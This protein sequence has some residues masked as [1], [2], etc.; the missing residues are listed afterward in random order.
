M[1]KLF[2]FL[3]FSIFFLQNSEAQQLPCIPIPGGIPAG[4]EAPGCMLCSPVYQGSTAGY[5]ASAPGSSGFPCGTVENNSFIS[6][7]VDHTGYLAA[8]VLSANCQNGQGIQIMLYDQ[9]F[10]PVSNCFSSGGTNLPGNVQA[11][12]L[13]PGEVYWLMIDGFAGDICDVLIT[14]F[15]GANFFPPDPPGHITAVP[16]TTLCVNLTA[17]YSI[18]EVQGA[19]QYSWEVPGNATIISGGGSQDLEVCLE[20]FAPGGGVVK[21]TPSNIC[22]EGVPAIHPVS[23]IPNLPDLRPVAY[24]CE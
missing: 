1:K 18:D 12:G 9:D 22:H 6:I 7:L 16:D 4:N 15:G 13:T 5:T 20:Y 19:N 14:V 8:N 3:I 23:V 10:N 24:F 2:S 21:V 17:C 11:A